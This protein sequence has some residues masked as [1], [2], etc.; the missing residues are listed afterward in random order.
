[1]S[2][3]IRLTG[4]DIMPQFGEL[5]CP[6]CDV[7]LKEYTFDM[8]SW[9]DSDDEYDCVTEEEERG[10]ECPE[11]GLQVNITHTKTTAR[12]AK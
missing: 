6:D 9:E 1:M 3:P 5:V 4:C 2:M 10:Y 8:D 7:P 11:C 12:K